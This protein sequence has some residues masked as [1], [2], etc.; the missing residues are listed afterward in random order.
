MPFEAQELAKFSQAGNAFA[1]AV[2]A[3]FETWAMGEA[4]VIC[5]QWAGAIPDAK[6]ESVLL[7]TRSKATAEAQVNTL[8]AFNVT[9][10][11]GRQGGEIGRVWFRTRRKEFQLAGKVT[12]SGQFNPSNLHYRS[13]DAFRISMAAEGYASI[14]PRIIKAGQ[15]AIGLARQSVVQIADSLGIA[16]ESVTGGGGGSPDLSKARNAKPSNGQT[17]QNGYGIKEGK[18]DN[19]SVTLVNRY[20]KMNE[21]GVTVAFEEVIAQRMAYSMANL[22]LALS[23]DTKKVTQAYPY[24]ETT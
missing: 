16:L 5:K 11:T 19:F 24:L 12:D 4:G 17:Y 7:G 1:D 15:E 22:G 20:P 13:E 21:S 23:K 14:L 2:G 9:V 18:G 8:A 10:N 3:S 6:P